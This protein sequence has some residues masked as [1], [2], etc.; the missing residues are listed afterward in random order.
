MGNQ[1][2]FDQREQALLLNIEQ[3][4]F[5]RMYSEVWCEERAKNVFW[6]LINL[7]QFHFEST[8]E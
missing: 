1:D 6:L 2:Y 7:H 5:D 4:V 3:A 8:Y